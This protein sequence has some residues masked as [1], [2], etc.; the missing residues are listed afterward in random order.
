[1]ADVA[2]SGTRRESGLQW[3]T[4][5]DGLDGSMTKSRKLEDIFICACIR[6]QK[7]TSID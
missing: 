5:L 3:L 6:I 4:E 1:M 7:E 2:I